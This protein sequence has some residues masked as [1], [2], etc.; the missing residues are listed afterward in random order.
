[1]E[2][3]VWSDGAVLKRLKEDYVLISMFV[4]DK[5]ALPED[6]KYVSSFSGNKIKTL[7]AWYSDIQVSKYQTN[8]QPFYVL[9]DNNGNLLN[10]V[11]SFN[12]DIPEY[13]KW[14]D[15]GLEEYKKR[16]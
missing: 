15:K 11:R 9:L 5:T 13:V 1:M 4:D 6:Q 16:K 14:L 2:A 3:A 7:G 8:T 12:E 10:D